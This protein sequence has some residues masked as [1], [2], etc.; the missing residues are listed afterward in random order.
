[1]KYEQAQLKIKRLHPDAI[2]PT[3][4]HATDSG[5]DLHA[6]EDVIIEPGETVLI[7]TGLAIQIPPGHEI[8]IR[9]RSGITSKTKLRVQLGTVDE[10]YTG[11]LK[12]AVDNIAPIVFH[13]DEKFKYC[14]V[15]PTEYELQ[16]ADMVAFGISDKYDPLY[17][18][19]NYA[20][21]IRKGDRIA[22]AV[23]APITR[24]QQFV[25]VDDFDIETDRGANGFGS[26]G[27][28]KDAI[29]TKDGVV[30]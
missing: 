28:S 29:F 5:F 26:T 13:I 20:Y 6:I 10:G 14:D 17:Y 2:V 12:V 23:L 3:Y 11:E 16:P 7:R 1:L 15:D 22:Q 18:E 25:E 24:V 9:P 19:Y 21:I 27:V 4:A 30:E 8:Q